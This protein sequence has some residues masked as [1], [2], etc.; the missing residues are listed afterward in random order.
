MRRNTFEGDV[1]HHIRSAHDE[2]RGGKLSASVY[3]SILRIGL[4]M[5]DIC[6]Q[7]RQELPLLPTHYLRSNA[8]RADAKWT[9]LVL[10]RDPSTLDSSNST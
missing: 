1:E 3:A 5:Y 10:F 7:S 6:A 2:S 8:R 4:I 9:A